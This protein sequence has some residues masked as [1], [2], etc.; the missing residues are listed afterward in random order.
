MTTGILLDTNIIVALTSRLDK[1]RLDVEEQVKV[2][3]LTC[4]EFLIT[5]TT[6]SELS[7]FIDKVRKNPGTDFVKPDF[8]ELSNFISSKRV[9][10]IDVNKILREENKELINRK[11]QEVQRTR[12][13][14]ISHTATAFIDAVLLLASED[15]KIPILTLDKSLKR[16][17]PQSLLEW[18][19]PLPFDLSSLREVPLNELMDMSQPLRE[20]YSQ[21]FEN[22]KVKAELAKESVRSAREAEELVSDYKNQLSQTEAQ[23]NALKEEILDKANGEKFWREAAKPDAAYMIGWTVIEIAAGF[24]PVPIPTSPISYF[25]DLWKYNRK[26]KAQEQEK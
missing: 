5:G 2:A 4:D 25:I 7:Q 21:S 26:L 22:Y 8:R 18:Y 17:I 10:R 13:H 24:I 14:R 23:V 12:P 16:L 11:M 6:L 3:S 19:A 9:R 1:Q 20:I 15:L